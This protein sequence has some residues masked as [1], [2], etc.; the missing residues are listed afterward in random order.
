MLAKKVPRLRAAAAAFRDDAARAS[1]HTNWQQACVSLEAT[2]AG[3]AALVPPLKAP[4]TSPGFPRTSGLP[5]SPLPPGSAKAP[6][7]PP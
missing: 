1:T 4:P 7:A 6:P 2:V 3:L 5:K